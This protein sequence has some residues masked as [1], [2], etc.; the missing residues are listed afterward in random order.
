MKS[1]S[2]PRLQGGPTRCLPTS[3]TTGRHCNYKSG[4][5]WLGRVEKKTEDDVAMRTWKRVVRERK[6]TNTEVKTCRTKRHIRDR[7]T[8]SYRRDE[9]Q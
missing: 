8:K 4:L 7:R 9:A 5:R 3:V 1:H 2:V 6:A